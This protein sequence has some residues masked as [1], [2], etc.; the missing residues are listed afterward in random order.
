MNKTVEHINNEK[1]N[2]FILF[3][4]FFLLIFNINSSLSFTE[5]YL[6]HWSTYHHDDIV[7]VYNS[8]LYLEGIELH[9]LDHPSLFTFIIFPKKYTYTTTSFNFIL[10][11]N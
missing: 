7:F 9:H 11:V 8:L 10:I 2:Y 1:I 6:K 4:V 3:S 5:D